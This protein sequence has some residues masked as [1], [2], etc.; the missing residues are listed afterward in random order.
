[1]QSGNAVDRVA[2]NDRHV[3]HLHL[4]IIQDRHLADLLL[5]VNAEYVG[6]SRLNLLYKTAVDLLDDLVNSGQKSLEQINRPLFQCLGHNCMVR[7][8][9][10]SR[11]NV[12]CLIPAEIVIV[13]QDTHQLG[14]CHRGMRIVQLE[15]YLLR[16]L[17]NIFMFAHELLHRLLH[18]CGDEEILL[19]QAQLLTCIVVVIGVKHFHDV[20]RKVLL[21]HRLAVV[22]LVEGIQLEN[23]YRLSIPDTQGI[24]NAIS[25]ADDREVKGNCPDRLIILLLK[26]AASKFITVHGDMSA[27]LDNLRILRSAKLKGISVLKPVVGN[28]HLI[29]VL[30]LLLKHTVAVADAA[31][32]G[33]IAKGRKGIQK[34]C[35]QSAETAVSERCVRLLILHNVQVESKLLQ[36]FLHNIGSL[37]VDDVVSEGTTHQEL[38]RHIINHFRILLLIRLL[39][40]DPVIHDLILDCKGY[41]LKYLLCGRLLQILAVKSLYIINNTSL[42]KLFVKLLLS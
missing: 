14:D 18:G 29:A 21:L 41:R 38:H 34:T 32:V 2:G 10:G 13:H 30:D 19:L 16:E 25:V 33:G 11:R 28:L 37:K 31:A 9:T 8:R 3:S 35:R 42:E 20:S 39:R 22:S 7:V 5:Y 12:P 26:T 15:G 4:S 24:Y 1:M 17:V 6:I 36:R 27:E 23:L 40:I